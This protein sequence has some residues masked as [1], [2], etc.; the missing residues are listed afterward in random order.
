MAMN[1]Q[2]FLDL[3]PAY[4]LGLLD[5]EDL[6]RFEKAMANADPEMLAAY[7]DAVNTAADLSLAAPEE[8]L[9]P[10]VLDTLMARIASTPGAAASAPAASAP[11]ASAPAAS[12]P[13]SAKHR[14]AWIVPFRFA[15]TVAVGLALVT[16]GLLAYVASL[17]ENMGR[18]K[19]VVAES[20]VRIQVLEDSLAQ[21]VAMLEVIK[22]NQMQMV[23]M[24]GL[25]AD[26]GGY[27]KI[28]WDPVRKQAILHVSNLPAQPA[29]KDYQL[30]VI[31]DKVP[32]DA[33]VFQVRGN[34]QGEGGELYKIDDLVEADK[35]RISAFAITLEPKGGLK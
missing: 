25:E 31:R 32:V 29:D 14:I 23:V 27:G 18:I 1:R 13:V 19:T 22:S 28:I 16:L 12:A 7:R 20:S 35:S 26:P 3:V 34:R 9:S 15:A 6:V 5:G 21:R 30:W 10:S 2:E 17:Q 24:N 8:S 4:A 33:G 11:A